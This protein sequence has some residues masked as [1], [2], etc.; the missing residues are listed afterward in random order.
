MTDEQFDNWKTLI[1]HSKKQFLNYYSKIKDIN[2]VFEREKEYT[3]KIYDVIMKV[4]KQKNFYKVAK[5]NVL[6]KYREF[7]IANGLTFEEDDISEAL[8]L[9]NDNYRE[10]Y[11][12]RGHLYRPIFFGEED[13]F[14][15]FEEDDTCGDCGCH[16]GKQHLPNCDI[17]RCPCCGGQMLSCDCGV[18]YSIDD[19]N[20][21][22]IPRLKHEQELQNAELDKMYDELPEKHR[23]NDESEM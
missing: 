12:I 14:W 11:L 10:N 16:Y 8:D 15:D 7:I 2:P 17:E 19:T 1:E 22:D 23:K 9:Y 3:L 4:G 18:I 20:K 5:S 13:D 21:D 6:N